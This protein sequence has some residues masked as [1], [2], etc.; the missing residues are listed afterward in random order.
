MNIQKTLR[1]AFFCSIP[2]KQREFVNGLVGSNGEEVDLSQALLC[3]QRKTENIFVTIKAKD[4]LKDVFTF[5][6]VLP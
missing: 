2:E 4:A 1:A 5:L 3:R 6:S